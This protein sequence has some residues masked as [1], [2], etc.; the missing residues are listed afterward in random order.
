MLSFYTL[1]SHNSWSL[2]IAQNCPIWHSSIQMVLKILPREKSRHHNQ[3]GLTFLI[4]S[5][6]LE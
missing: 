1:H 3:N 5:Y 2:Q 6:K 4:T